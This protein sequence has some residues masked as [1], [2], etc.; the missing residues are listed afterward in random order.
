MHFGV[1][2]IHRSLVRHTHTSSYNLNEERTGL[3]E[4]MRE[5]VP[6]IPTS[7]VAPDK[8]SFH[9]R[10]GE[11]LPTRGP[12]LGR[13][14]RPVTSPAVSRAR[15]HHLREV[16]WQSH[17]LL[18]S[19]A[20]RRPVNEGSREH[21]KVRPAYPESLH[22]LFRAV[23]GPVCPGR[24]Q[25][26]SQGAR[27]KMK[28]P[29][30]HGDSGRRPATSALPRYSSRWRSPKVWGDAAVSRTDEQSRL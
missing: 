29:R 20:W 23:Q 18:R 10:P 14:A 25:A 4:A 2:V 16:R 12:G 1:C 13:S 5:F 9:L 11:E 17:H 21:R 15:G 7:C 22:R 30:P 3:S 6:D 8:L 19:W 26:G 27:R 24:Q 28:S